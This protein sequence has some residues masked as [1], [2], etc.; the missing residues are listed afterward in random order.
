MALPELRHA[1]RFVIDRV[2]VG[3]RVDSYKLVA[4]A[5]RQD[6]LDLVA[7]L[8]RQYPEAQVSLDMDMIR[9]YK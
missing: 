8:R 9:V 1:G 5:T 6:V 2:L 4:R 7:L 3:E